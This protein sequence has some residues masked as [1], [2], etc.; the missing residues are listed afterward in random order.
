MLMTRQLTLVVIQNN[1]LFRC[2]LFFFQLASLRQRSPL[3]PEDMHTT[4]ENVSTP[5]LTR[6]KIRRRNLSQPNLTGETPSTLT[7]VPMVLP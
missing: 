6:E 7:L 3:L 2:E 5:T 4:T 1:R